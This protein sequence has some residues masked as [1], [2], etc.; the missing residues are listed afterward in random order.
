MNEVKAHSHLSASSAERW[1]KCPGSVSLSK[2]MPPQPTSPYAAEGTLAHSWLEYKLKVAF[3]G[4]AVQK[5]DCEMSEDMEEAVD[6]GLN[7]IT[8]RFMFADEKNVLIEHRFNLGFIHDGMFGTSDFCGL[9]SDGKLYVIDYKHGKGKVV[10]IEENHQLHYYAVGAVNHFDVDADTDVCMVIIQ[11]RAIGKP[12]KEQWKKA[13]EIHEWTNGLIIAARLADTDN[14]PLHEGEHCMW[15][16]AKAKCPKIADKLFSTVTVG[17]GVDDTVLAEK[18]L[19]KELI[20]PELL[21]KEQLINIISNK[22]MI[23]SWLESCYSFLQ[24]AAERGETIE[25]YKLVKRKANR[26]WRS[27]PEVMKEFEALG[28]SIFDE[29]KL[30]SPAQ[31]EKLK[32]LTPAQKEVLASLV[33]VPDTGVTLVPEADKRDAVAGVSADHMLFSVI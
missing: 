29:P 31:L 33:F 14:A 27:E 32:S 12:I 9:T 22:D 24:G 18:E 25:G 17:V 6:V 30:K 20:K 8:D 26:K 2:L 11:P 4:D 10:S 13:G 21:T 23:E 19:P 3:F 1:F 28:S 16:P 5:P 15:C 7:Y